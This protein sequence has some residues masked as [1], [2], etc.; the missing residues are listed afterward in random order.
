MKKSRIIIGMC[1]IV[2]LAMLVAFPG[3]AVAKPIKLIVNDHNPPFT[4][5]GQSIIYWAEQLNKMSGGRLELTVYSGAALLTGEEV[6][7]GVESGVVDIGDYVVDS[8]DGFI[9]NL[10]MSLPFMGW[11][12]Q[13]E[14][15]KLYLELLNW[16]K[17]MQAEWKGVT[18]ISVM[19]MPPTHIH[20]V[21][22]AIVVPADIRGMKIMG[23]ET[24]T[25]A[26]TEAAGATPVQIDI[27]EMAPALN[28]GLISGVINHMPVLNV[29]G[30]LELLHYH[31]IFGDGGI[32]M[33][34]M[35]LIMNT[36]KLNKLPPDL[37]KLLMDSGSIWY[38][39]F[40]EMDAADQVKAQQD[41]EN[42]GHKFTYLTPE[43]VKVWY[44]LVKGPI[45]DKWIK[46]AEAKGRAGKKVYKKALKLIKKHKK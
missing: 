30:A 25:V 4:G 7:R 23:A 44:D 40:K 39:K 22:K 34:P 11:P 19:M 26:A 9:L 31:T 18:I 15:G 42:W 5:P 21:K 38:N 8:R 32:N 6:Y 16:S 35:F 46:D 43:Q 29:F 13:H 36:K 33:T 20:T 27:M 17:E 10:I 45:H 41:A 3:F 24:M 2:M 1:L 37:K 12:E 14:A 28:T